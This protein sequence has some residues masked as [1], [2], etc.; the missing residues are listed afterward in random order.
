MKMSHST[1]TSKGQ[2]T[3]PQEIREAAGLRTGAKLN[4]TVTPDG[5]LIVRTK[6][7]SLASLAGSIKIQNS[8]KISIQD[9]NPWQ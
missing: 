5:V 8:P 1:L 7:Q 2:T 4:W 9:M 3:I 6:T